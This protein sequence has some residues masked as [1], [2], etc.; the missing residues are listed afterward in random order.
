MQNTIQLHRLTLPHEN[1]LHSLGSKYNHDKK[2][3]TNF[4]HGNL[5]QRKYVINE[6][7]PNK[8]LNYRLVIVNS[9]ILQTYVYIPAYYWKMSSLENCK[10][11]VLKTLLRDKPHEVPV[12]KQSQVWCLPQEST[13]PTGP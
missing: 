6:S 8:R 13:L 4:F 11:D 1:K 9:S 12:D 10:C 3:V 2:E 7:F 5:P